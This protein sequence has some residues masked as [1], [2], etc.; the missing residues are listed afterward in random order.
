LQL[1]C[2]PLDRIEKLMSI[3]VFVGSTYTDL[4][5]HRDAVRD[6]LVRQENAVRGME[7]FGSRPDGPRD[8][9]LRTV[10][11]CRIYIGV[12]GMRYGSIDPDTGRSF[13]HLEYDEAQR[14]HLPSLI[15]LMDEERHFIRP[16]DVEIGD[17]A[18][19]LITLKEV[20]VQNHVVSRFASP[21]DLAARVA[22]DLPALL[23]RDGFEARR[24]ELSRVV[25]SIRRID[26]LTDGR[27]RFLKAAL[28]EKAQPVPSDAVLREVIE[29][30]LSHDRQAA[31]FLI[32][33]TCG[34][35]FRE[36]IDL[37][38]Q[39]DDALGEVLKAGVARLDTTLGEP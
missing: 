7:Y 36:S 17:G 30:L 4:V 9:C 14:I 15:Y 39:L 38:R 32:A 31:T 26:W 20:L 8:E 19:K 10:R 6:V 5:A 37:A 13:T 34:L 12:F 23:S 3:P 16:R 2:G 24:G 11:S 25:D 21:D 27:F 18:S 22:Q 28:G 29:F 33:R 35:G 1:K